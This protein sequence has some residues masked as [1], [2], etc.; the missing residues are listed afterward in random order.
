MRTIGVI[1]LV[2]LSACNPPTLK[3]PVQMIAISTKYGEIGVG[4]KNLNIRS[5][6]KGVGEWVEQPRFM[7]IAHAP[8]N[9]MCF[10]MSIWLK[11]V[12]PKLKEGARYYDDYK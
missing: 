4:T 11:V 6:A 3:K 7:S 2:M 5:K 1:L 10:E 8:D 12:K 9:L